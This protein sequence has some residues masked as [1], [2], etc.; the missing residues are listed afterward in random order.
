VFAAV[1]AQVFR[2]MDNGV[3]WKMQISDTRYGAAITRM[4][5]EGARL[6]A[7]THDEFLITRGFAYSNWSASGFAVTSVAMDNNQA[8][9][10]LE[11]GVIVLQVDSAYNQRP[12]KKIQN[13]LTA[14]RAFPVAAHNGLV[15]NTTALSVPWI[16][17]RLIF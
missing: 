5:A 11:D 16:R 1:G 4:A 15:L 14:V 9:A 6:C 17:E 2:S 13:G 3:T 10:G 8:L 7:C 12:W